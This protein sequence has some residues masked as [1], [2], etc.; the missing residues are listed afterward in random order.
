M[1]YDCHMKKILILLLLVFSIAFNMISVQAHPGGTDSSGCH[2]CRTNCAQHGLFTGQRHCHNQRS[3]VPSITPPSTPRTTPSPNTTPT[4]RT[5]TSPSTNR[6]P[7]S[8][9]SSD[10]DYR[11]IVMII[12]IGVI[13]VISIVAINNGSSKKLDNSKFEQGIDNLKSKLDE[14]NK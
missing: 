7:N 1:I 8:V 11:F 5:P 14:L 12:A 6:T 4:P 13:G 9:N 2:V 10:D 3:T